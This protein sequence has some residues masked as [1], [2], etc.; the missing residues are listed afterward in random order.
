[1]T[2][3]DDASGLSVDKAYLFVSVVVVVVAADNNGISSRL[4]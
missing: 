3:N 1:V 2:V 4:D